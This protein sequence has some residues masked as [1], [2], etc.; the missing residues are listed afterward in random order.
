VIIEV[1][2]GTVVSIGTDAV[3]IKF[4]IIDRDLNDSTGIVT[5]SEPLEADYQGEPIKDMYADEPEVYKKLTK[6]NW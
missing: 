1:S 3:G 2:S 4:V 5:V 6:Y